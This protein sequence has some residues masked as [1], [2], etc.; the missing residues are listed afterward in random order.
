MTLHFSD[1]CFLARARVVDAFLTFKI[2]RRAL[3][4]DGIVSHWRGDGSLETSGD[5]SPVF[6]FRRRDTNFNLLLKDV[7]LEDILVKDVL[8]KDV[9]LEDYYWWMFFW[10]IYF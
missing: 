7:F 8:L 10:R 6:C 1:C 4:L 3:L 2:G 5:F 9:L